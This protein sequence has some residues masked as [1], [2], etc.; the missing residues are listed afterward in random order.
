MLN[1]LD[2]CKECFIILKINITYNVKKPIFH[3][4]MRI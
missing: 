4:E 3:I 2:I 1:M